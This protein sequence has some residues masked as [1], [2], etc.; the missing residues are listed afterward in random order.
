TFVLA[1][2]VLASGHRH[3]TAAER[4]EA[5]G[6]PERP[7]LQPVGAA[8]APADRPVIVAVGCANGADGTVDRAAT[9]ASEMGAPLEVVL[10]RETAIVGDLAVEAEDADHAH[11]AVRAH[12]NR[13]LERGMAASGLVLTSVGD[14]ASAALVLAEHASTVGAQ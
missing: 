4:S 11:A 5:E 1:I 8:P 9:L 14:H 6:E 2:G 12:L 13:V 10:V 7:V 3:I